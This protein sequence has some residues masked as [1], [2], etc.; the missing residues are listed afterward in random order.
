MNKYT[1]AMSFDFYAESDEHA[2]ELTEDRFQELMNVGKMRYRLHENV[3]CRVERAYVKPVGTFSMNS[4]ANVFT[5]LPAAGEDIQTTS[6]RMAAKAAETAKGIR[7]LFNGT[8][9]VALPGWSPLQVRD[10]WAANRIGAGLFVP[11]P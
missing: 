6:E 9:V 7:G 11:W 3:Q 2:H 10:W 5:Y 8:P 1:A 4:K